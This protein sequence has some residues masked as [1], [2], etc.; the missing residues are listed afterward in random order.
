LYGIAIFAPLVRRVCL[1]SAPRM[2][3]APAGMSSATWRPPTALG[4]ADAMAQRKHGGGCS[5]D[6]A[7]RIDSSL[8][9]ADPSVPCGRSRRGA[10]LVARGSSL[11][12]HGQEGL[13]QLGFVPWHVDRVL[14]QV[15]ASGVA[16]QFLGKPDR[17]A[18]LAFV[19]LGPRR[20]SS[21]LQPRA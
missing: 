13:E 17:E 4:S 1:A 9:T 10:G 11:V 16:Q 15:A 19:E 20:G 14:A 2:L 8:A 18:F 6:G 3:E 12:A 21:A 7:L 5:A